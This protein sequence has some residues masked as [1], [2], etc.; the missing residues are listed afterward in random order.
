MIHHIS[1]GQQDLGGHGWEFLMLHGS[2]YSVD[3]KRRAA[4]SWWTPGYSQ[5]GGS[6]AKERPFIFLLWR[7]VH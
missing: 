3:P 1:R 4:V 5:I 7:G 6:H 2:A